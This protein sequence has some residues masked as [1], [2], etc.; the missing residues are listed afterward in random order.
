LN[1]FP[2]YKGGDTLVVAGYIHEYCP[3]HHLANGWGFVAQHRLIAEDKIGRPLVR[4]KEAVHHI[5]HCPT[6]NHP[7]NLQVMDWI[8]HTRM[9]G[10]QST[11]NALDL[12]R[13]QVV[14]ALSGR[15]L[16]QA[17][18]H[19]KC[20][21]KTLRRRFPDLLAPRQRVSP[22]KIDDPRDLARVLQAATDPQIGI[23]ALAKE[24]RMSPSTILRICRRNGK[25]W[26]RQRR[27][28]ALP[29]ARPEFRRPRRKPREA[30]AAEVAT[31]LAAAVD[32]A[33]R[34]CDL[35]KTVDLPMREVHRVCADHKVKWSRSK[36]KPSLRA[37]ARYAS[38]P[39]LGEPRP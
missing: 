14:E 13:E 17:A 5:D 24:L 15:N 16:K 28:E 6:N 2:S 22:T 10:K 25:P 7:D 32:P 39:A 19:L 34:Y 30:T 27:R 20:D 11:R 18:R 3:R 38:P 23:H 36:H 9:H 4:K 31:I 1:E 33:I 26:I 29:R 37:S 21:T 8:E 12:S 35:V